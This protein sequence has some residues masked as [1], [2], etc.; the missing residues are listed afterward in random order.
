M[1]RILLLK[2]DKNAARTLP[3]KGKELLKYLDCNLI[4]QLN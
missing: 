1:V 2:E 3:S 4:F